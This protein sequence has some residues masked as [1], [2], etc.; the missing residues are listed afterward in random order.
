MSGAFSKRI[1]DLRYKTDQS[2]EYLGVLL[3]K[4]RETISKY[5]KGER[6]PGLEVV[7]RLASHFGVS[8]D[9]ILGLTDNTNAVTANSELY[10]FDINEYK[11]YLCDIK[12]VK[13]L[14]LAVKMANNNIDIKHVEQYVDNLI[15]KEKL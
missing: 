2:Q 6:E 15:L 9:Y 12:F 14:K 8:T 11:P 7:T 10:P 5:E 4:S 3:G 1:R 13:Y